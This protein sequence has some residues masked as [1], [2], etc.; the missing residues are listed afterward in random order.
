VA[1]TSLRRSGVDA[2]AASDLP[3]K[4]G[5]PAERALAGVG[6]STLKQLTKFSEADIK[7]LHGIG[8]NALGKLNS[9]LAEKGLS[10]ADAI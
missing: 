9:A 3:S 2:N 5:K 6:I 8:P 7:K 10:F 1:K 4:L